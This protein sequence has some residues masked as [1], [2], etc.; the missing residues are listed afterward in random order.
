MPLPL[1]IATYFT[2]WWVVLFAVLPFGV[3]SATEAGAT[4]L[5]SGADPGAPA[6]PGLGVKALWTTAIAALVFAVVDAY[7]YWAG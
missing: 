2:I 1:S 6:A 5:P 3:R 7:V 4:D